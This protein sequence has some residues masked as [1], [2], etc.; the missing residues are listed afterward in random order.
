MTR[1]EWIKNASVED[2]AQM[3]SDLTIQTIELSANT[4]REDEACRGC[5]AYDSCSHKQ[6][7][8]IDWLNKEVKYNNTKSFRV[9][10]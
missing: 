8:F 7:G 5:V 3:L 1:Y 2:L 6:N 9:W 4:E 10:D